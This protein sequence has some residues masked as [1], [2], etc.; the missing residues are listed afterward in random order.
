MAKLSRFRRNPVRSTFRS[1]GK[2]RVPPGLRGDLFVRS[3]LV[4]RIADERSKE[5]LREFAHL[6]SRIPKDIWKGGCGAHRKKARP[7]T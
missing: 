4:P 2:R 6:N 1:A 3:G 7:P 5:I